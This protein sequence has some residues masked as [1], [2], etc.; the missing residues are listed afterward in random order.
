[1]LAYLWVYLRSHLVP[2]HDERGADL[3]EYALLLAFIAIAVIG[4]VTT[5]GQQIRAVFPQIA[6]VLGSVL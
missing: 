3:A 2:L 4:A 5:I 1:M 6:E